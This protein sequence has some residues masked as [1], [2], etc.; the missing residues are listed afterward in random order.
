MS[1]RQQLIITFEIE[2]GELDVTY[3]L[4]PDQKILEREGGCTKEEA[5]AFNLALTSCNQVY[6]YLKKE[7]K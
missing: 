2:D 3:R 4:T 7:V 6:E 1:I 5:D